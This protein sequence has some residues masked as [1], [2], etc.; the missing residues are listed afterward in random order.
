[1]GT[2]SARQCTEI[3][4]NS[5]DVIAIEL[6]CAA[7]AM[8]L[9]TNVKP[10]EGTLEAYTVIRKTISHLDRDRILSQDIEAMKYLMRSGKILQVVEKKVGE[11]K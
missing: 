6:L 4:K 10:G 7:Q 5:E 1:M 3:I 2:I 9:F 11:L 8:D